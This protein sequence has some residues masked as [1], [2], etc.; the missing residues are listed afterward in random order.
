[1]MTKFYKICKIG[2]MSHSGTALLLYVT[3]QA[4][5]GFLLHRSIQHATPGTGF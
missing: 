2:F 4:I 5:S 1:M 3:D